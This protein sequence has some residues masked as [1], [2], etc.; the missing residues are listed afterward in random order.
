MPE[1]STETHSR[2]RRRSPEPLDTVPSKSPRLLLTDS[3]G[4]TR[5]GPPQTVAELGDEKIPQGRLGDQKAIA[6]LVRLLESRDEGIQT[7]SR[8]LEEDR[9]LQEVTAATVQNLVRRVE[10]MGNRL[11]AVEKELKLGKDGW[12]EDDL[13]STPRI[14]SGPS[15][16]HKTPRMR[17]SWPGPDQHSPLIPH[18]LGIVPFDATYYEQRIAPSKQAMMR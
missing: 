13:E 5:E 18:D 11:E 8:R 15:L 4:V 3:T 16:G 2:K 6:A 17:H 10:K 12:R 14:S 7:L 9:L 1:T